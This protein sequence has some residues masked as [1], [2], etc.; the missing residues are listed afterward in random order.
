MDRIRV[1]DEHDL[2]VAGRRDQEQ[3][4]VSSPFPVRPSILTDPKLGQLPFDVIEVIAQCLAEESQ[5]DSNDGTAQTALARLNRVSKAV[6]AVT[7]AALYETT[8]YFE[9]D[10]FTDSVGPQ[11]S[12]GWAWTK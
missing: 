4:R 7:L 6:H 1:E 2:S 5:V 12:K 10:D 8:D 9:K 11:N 3:I